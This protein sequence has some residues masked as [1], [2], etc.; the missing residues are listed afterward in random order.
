[1]HLFK[2]G[3]LGEKLVWQLVSENTANGVRE[4]I[5]EARP[6]C[7][8]KFYRTTVSTSAL[9]GERCHYEIVW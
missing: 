7:F 4:Q 8:E 5:F 6:K 9:G 1:M 3:V 2:R